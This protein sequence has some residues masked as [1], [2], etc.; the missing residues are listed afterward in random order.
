M[1][2]W[3]RVE[4]GDARRLVYVSKGLPLVGSLLSL[5]GLAGTAGTA[6]Q[7]VVS[8]LNGIHDWHS[9]GGYAAGV[10]VCFVLL[11]VGLKMLVSHEV[12]F[13]KAA[14]VFVQTQRWLAWRRSVTTK[15]ENVAAV[16]WRQKWRDSNSDTSTRVYPVYLQRRD[17][18]VQ[19]FETF[20]PEEARRLT[21]EVASSLGLEAVH[22]DPE[23]RLR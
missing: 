22:P 19:L 11:V 18:E 23:T 17:E 2:T 13:D 10:L 4:T 9:L 1:A 8:Y 21:E 15:L 3:Q 7:F 6:E 12:V 5:C 20:R 14:S 16:V